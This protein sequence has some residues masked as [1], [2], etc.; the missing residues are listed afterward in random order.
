MLHQF[1]RNE[2]AIGK[3]GLEKLKNATVAVLGVGGVGSFAVEALARSGIGRLVLVDRDN[4][5]ITNINRQIHALLS[6]IGRPK[7]ELM[8]ERI[9][10]INPECE[11]I[12]LQMFY[13]EETYEQFFSYD[14]DFVIDASDTIIYKVHLMKECLK[15]NIPIISSM[16]AANKMD[17]TRFRIVDISK[18][19][20][21]PIAKIIR[22]KLRKEGIRSGI[23][24]VFS[25]ER[26]IIIREDVRKVV[27]NDQSP[28]RKAQMPPSSNAFVPSVAGLI[29]ASYVVRELLKDIKIYR[30]G[31]E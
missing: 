2:L 27:G 13:T 14:L 9:A 8:K 15:R 23:P 4:V 1:S 28:I 5:D 26:P 20:T 25:D 6:T 10:D 31:E 21:D 12:A 18:T 30:V 11:V 22:S 7:V 3:E 17:P 24:V 29:M 16:G 19:H